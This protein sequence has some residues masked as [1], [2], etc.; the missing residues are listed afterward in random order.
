[1]GDR[2]FRLYVLVGVGLMLWPLAYIK[3]TAHY[4]SLL[5]VRQEMYAV[6]DGV[7]YKHFRYGQSNG[8]ANFYRGKIW[9]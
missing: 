1:M 5:S 9:A 6:R 2:L 8:K 4:R 7:Y 3:T